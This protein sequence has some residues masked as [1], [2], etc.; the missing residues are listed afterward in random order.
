LIFDQRMWYAHKNHIL[1]KF[2]AFAKQIWWQ[3]FLMHEFQKSRADQEMAFCRKTD[4]KIKSHLD[5][6]LW[7][8][9]FKMMLEAWFETGV[10]EH[11]LTRWFC[12][13]NTY[14]KEKNLFYYD[15]DA[16]NGGEEVYAFKDDIVDKIRPHMASIVERYYK[17]KWT[18]RR[19][20]FGRCFI[21]SERPKLVIDKSYSK[22]RKIV[23]D[24]FR[25]LHEKE[26]LFNAQD[27]NKILAQTEK[28]M[29][30]KLNSF[31]RSQWD[32]VK[33]IDGVGVVSAAQQAKNKKRKSIKQKKSMK[34]VR[35]STT[36]NTEKEERKS[37]KTPKANEKTW[38]HAMQDFK[39]VNKRKKKNMTKE[40]KKKLRQKR[41]KQ[42]QNKN[43]QSSAHQ[44]RSSVK[45]P[46]SNL[47]ANDND[48]SGS[49][50]GIKMIQ[51][52]TTN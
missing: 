30:D 40:E 21:A 8:Q 48:G 32:S 12:Q 22:F 2:F 29:D 1:R 4:S 45:N 27:L 3:R 9:Y 7:N 31:N 46:I 34:K 33:M 14:S 49:G 41:E 44:K 15:N 17:K 50:G 20:K 16:D 23:R 13:F 10:Y 28:E 37:I 24:L 52:T 51:P 38:S 11:A 36:A 19:M 5:C 26:P 6:P 18:K 42:L 25:A 43:E 35:I 47:N 39:S